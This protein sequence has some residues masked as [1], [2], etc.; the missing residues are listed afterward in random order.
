MQ[1]F[2]NFA[3]LS[4]KFHNITF[5]SSKNFAFFV[6]K[7]PIFRFFKSNFRIFS[8]KNLKLCIF[9]SKTQN[10]TF[11]SSKNSIFSHFQFH[12]LIFQTQKLQ[13]F[14]PKT[15]FSI[16][17]TTIFQIVITKDPKFSHFQFQRPQ[18]FTFQTL[19]S[20][21]SPRNSSNATWNPTKILPLTRASQI[22]LHTKQLLQLAASE[23]PPSLEKNI[24]GSGLFSWRLWVIL[25]EEKKKNLQGPVARVEKRRKGKMK[26]SGYCSWEPCF[27]RHFSI[28]TSHL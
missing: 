10:F 18:I 25:F 23:R 1:K 5:F 27:N 24:E 8:S 11:F 17:K 22:P 14:T 19:Q 3:F 26:E 16:Q 12:K 20:L 28:Q 2:W 9:S 7:I 4:Q 6:L 15:L 13:I 21:F